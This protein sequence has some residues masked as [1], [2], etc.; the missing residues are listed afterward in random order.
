MAAECCLVLSDPLHILYAKVNRFLNKGPAW[1]VEKL[2]SSWVEQIVMRLPSVDDE[3]YKEIGW[4]LNVLTEGL[5]TSAVSISPS[6]VVTLS[7]C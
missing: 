5:R 6:R 3:Y 7:N 1:K 4:L 2:P